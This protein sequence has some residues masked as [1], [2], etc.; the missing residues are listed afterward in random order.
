MPARQ[1]F[2]GTIHHLI[3]LAFMVPAVLALGKPPSGNQSFFGPDG[4]AL[5]HLGVAV[6]VVHQVIVWLGFR[7][8]L[9]FR[10]FTRL[11]GRMDIAAWGVIFLPLLM[12]RVI[13]LVAAGL[14]DQGS[15]GLSRA[16]AVPAGITLIGLALYTLWSV[17][18]YFGLARALGADH[19]RVEYR[20]MPFEKR[21]AFRLSDNAMYTFA[22][23]GLWGA[24][25][26]LDSRNA[27]AL[28]AF[29]HAYIWVHWYCVEA[30][31]ISFIYR[32]PD[33]RG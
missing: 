5:F 28:A 7:G 25:L 11:F 1:F 20:D 12:L 18:R 6:P 32:K 4:L 19:F 9:C 23:L 3:L 30:P 33:S 13:S 15:L 16:L 2:T 21:G 26:L 27:L 14:A 22:F 17:F 24:A 29:Q 8:Q 10:V 31:D